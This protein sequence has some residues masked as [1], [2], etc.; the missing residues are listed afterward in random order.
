MKMVEPQVLFEPSKPH[1]LDVSQR[2]A[3]DSFGRSLEAMM[4]GLRGFARKLC[5]DADFAEDLVQDT[6]LR[7]W[8]G[9]ESFVEGTNLKAWTFT[10]L[11]NAFLSE[12]RRNRLRTTVPMGE[13]VAMG[14]APPAQEGSIHLNELASVLAKL[15]VERRQAVML[16][17]VEGLSYEEAAVK[18]GCPTGTIKSRVARARATISQ[19]LLA[20]P[21]F[22]A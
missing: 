5:L 18:C 14:S 7:A 9:R 1:L 19:E 11:R 4:P 21:Q 6:V 2:A 15:P 17:A 12:V 8:R 13:E 3:R 22:Q 10:I 16:V 20:E